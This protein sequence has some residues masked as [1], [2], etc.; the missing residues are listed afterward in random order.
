MQKVMCIVMSIITT[1]TFNTHTLAISD[2]ETVEPT[3]IVE[4][5]E[6]EMAEDIPEVVVIEETPIEEEPIVEVVEPEDIQE[7]EEVVIE[8]PSVKE[9]KLSDE[10]VELIAKIAMAES[11]GESEEGQR[12]VIDTIL[13]RMDHERFPSTAHDVI[14]QKNQFST[15]NSR[16]LKRVTA[17]KELCQL[18][19]EEAT[20]RTN[21][22]VV[23]F[24]TKHYSRYG[25]PVFQVGNHYF[26][27]Y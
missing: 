8:E 25:T 19:R 5:Y 22:D 10:D 14:Y 13:N 18:V 16:T 12:L 20:A 1:L 21:S 3:E 23:F 7:T 6:P 11:R 15:A 26:S 4:T 27:K 2:Y 17:T 24:R 9:V